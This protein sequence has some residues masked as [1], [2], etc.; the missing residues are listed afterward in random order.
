[1]K[2]KQLYIGTEKTVWTR[3]IFKL[4]L[5]ILSSLSIT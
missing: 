5:K 2:N 3:N 4:L 1:M